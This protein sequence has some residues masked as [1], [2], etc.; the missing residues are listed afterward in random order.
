MNGAADLLERETTTLDE[1]AELSSLPRPLR[2]VLLGEFSAGKS[3]LVNLLVGSDLVPT[4]VLATTRRLI[5]LHYADRIQLA[6]IDSS[7]ERREI[8]SSLAA[9]FNGADGHFEI[10][11]PCARLKSMVLIDTPG[12]AD[13]NRDPAEALAAAADCDVAIWCTRAQQ[14]WRHSEHAIWSSLPTHVHETGL[15]VATRSDKLEK[16][17]DRRSVMARLR[18]EAGA[19][20]QD[21]VLLSTLNAQQ[22]QGKHPGELDVALWKRSGGEA[23]ASGLM[24]SLSRAVKHVLP[25]AADKA[26]LPIDDHS[27]PSDH[28]HGMSHAATPIAVVVGQADDREESGADTPSAV[29]HPLR[30]VPGDHERAVVETVVTVEGESDIDGL[31][32]DLVRT[33][34][35]CRLAA[36]IDLDRTRSLAMASDR[37]AELA[38]IGDELA[39][40]AASLLAGP[41]TEPIRDMIAAA[42]ASSAQAD[43]M[44]DTVTLDRGDSAYVFWRRTDRPDQAVV[45]AAAGGPSMVASLGIIQVKIRQFLAIAKAVA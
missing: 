30:E 14:A 37:S 26:D 36:C 32:A 28:G 12:L 4:G 38:G 8:E 18:Q 7:G 29:D 35:G 39:A 16:A 24:R 20:F 5:K 1:F 45:L 17:S 25:T 19:M 13:P 2:V 21:V 3:S 15:L 31:L 44:I 10:G 27:P 42:G 34:D 23:L 41:A 40:L 43:G 22:A 9:Q 6:A 33:I 11:L